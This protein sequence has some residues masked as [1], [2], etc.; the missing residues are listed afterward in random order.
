MRRSTATVLA[1]A[2]GLAAAAFAGRPSDAQS[3]TPAYVVVEVKVDVANDAAYR[4]EF[5]DL[6]RPLIEKEGGRYLVRSGKSDAVEGEAP[7]KM[8]IVQFDDLQQ[9]AAAF[10]SPA[11]RELR[12]IGDK[13]GTFRIVA[14]EGIAQP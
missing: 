14:I 6:V 5:A 9:A 13:Y 7:S 4:K 1:A 10:R 11:Y 8:A 12:K 3:K 2:L